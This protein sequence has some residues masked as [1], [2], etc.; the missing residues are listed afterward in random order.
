MK[1]KKKELRSF[2]V[3]VAISIFVFLLVIEIVRCHKQRILT[4]LENG[5]FE[6]FLLF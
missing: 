2:M 6:P 3:S 4:F 5:N 1:V